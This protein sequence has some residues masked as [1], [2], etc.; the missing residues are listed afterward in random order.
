M[1]NIVSSGNTYDYN[2]GADGTPL[3]VWA[4]NPTDGDLADLSP[5][6][7]REIDKGA[8]RRKANYVGAPAIFALE[9]AC[10]QV[11]EA[12]GGFGC[13]LVGSALDRPD[14]RDVDVRLI[15]KDEEFA[16]L[17]PDAGHAW[18]QDARWLLLTVSISERLAKL[19]GLP[20]DF[21][22]QPMTHANER[23]SG[24]RHAIGFRIHNLREKL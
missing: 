8:P 17:F 16:V 10:Q 13:Y 11:H 19:T 12:I 22:I 24:R 14:W 2:I 7:L 21:Q 23:H 9:S 6:L 1:P 5:V 3:I 15:M 20:V 18:E 4:R